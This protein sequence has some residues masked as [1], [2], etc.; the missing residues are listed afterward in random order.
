M[1]AERPAEIR[2]IVMDLKAAKPVTN[3]DRRTCHRTVP[4]KII[5]AG[6]SRSGTSCTSFCTA[7][8]KDDEF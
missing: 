7:L 3:I 6:L 4:M 2:P 8:V 1:A 5:G